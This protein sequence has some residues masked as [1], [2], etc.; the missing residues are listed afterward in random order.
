MVGQCMAKNRI[1]AEYKVVSTVQKK[2]LLIGT[3]TNNA[4]GPSNCSISKL[5][6]STQ[7][8]TAWYKYILVGS[9]ALSLVR[10]VWL[11]SRRLSLS[12][13]GWFRG[14]QRSSSALT[15]RQVANSTTPTRM[16]VVL[17]V[18]SWITA[19][20]LFCSMEA[21]KLCISSLFRQRNLSLHM[22]SDTTI[23]RIDRRS[24]GCDS[25]C[26]DVP[27]THSI[28]SVPPTCAVSEAFTGSDVTI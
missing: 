22:N 4:G 10:T 7:L 2:R 5:L 11:S 23:H 14:G 18:T 20:Q 25:G 9:L 17:F 13:A 26:G 8:G 3:Q 28:F 21:M 24:S 16:D 6:Y 15:I 1:Q 19:T 12:F 27:V